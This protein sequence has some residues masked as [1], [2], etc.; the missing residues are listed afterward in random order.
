[1]KLTEANMDQ[2]KIGSFIAECRKEKNLT[3]AELA[4]KF[5]ISDRAVSKWENGRCL[6]DAAIML[7]LCEVLGVSVNE[8]LKGERLGGSESDAKKESEALMVELKKENEVLTKKI[9]RLEWL[10]GLP[11]LLAFLALEFEGSYVASVQGKDS[12]FAILLAI[13]GFFVML[14]AAFVGV[15][16]EQTAGWYECST[17]GHRQRPSYAQTLFAPHLSR[18]RLMNCPECKKRT[19]QKKVTAKE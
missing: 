14:P 16:I 8:L 6:P 12:P 10:M 11:V 5:G 13:S 4:Q 7:G 18:T 3:Q 17:C 15:W 19:W 9:L 2:I 1:M